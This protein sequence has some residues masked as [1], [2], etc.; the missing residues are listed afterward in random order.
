RIS[1]ANY[2]PPST[3]YPD[4]PPPSKNLHPPTPPPTFPSTLPDFTRPRRYRL[5]DFCDRSAH[6]FPSPLS[7]RNTSSHQQPR[8]FRPPGNRQKSSRRLPLVAR[9]H[10]SCQTLHGAG[11]RA[12]WTSD[13]RVGHGRKGRDALSSD[14]R[15]K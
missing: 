8:P 10:V 4:P 3:R 1:T 2:H 11:T 12:V 15:R 13:E 6:P 9:G 7:D 14:M 5:T